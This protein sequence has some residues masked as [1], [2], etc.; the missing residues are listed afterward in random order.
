LKS[1]TLSIAGFTIC[2]QSGDGTDISVEDGYLP[3]IISDYTGKPDVIIHSERN[4]P[5]E[6]SKPEEVIFRAQDEQKKY[7]TVCKMG[8]AYKVL[9]YNQEANEK[10]Q[11]VALLNKDFSEWIIY[12]DSSYSN[13]TGYPLQYPLGP[14][15]L[16]YITVRFDAIMIHASGINDTSGGRIFCGFSGTGKSTMAAIWQYTGSTII[17]DDRLIIRKENEDYV[18]YNTPMLF[19]DQPKK[20]KLEA[21]HLIHH[22]LENTLNKLNGAFAVSSVMAFCIQNNY[23]PRFIDHH[24]AFLSELCNKIPVYEVGF[25]PDPSIIDFIKSH[26]D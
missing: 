9:I 18:I 1:I 24:L 16:Y 26:A 21:I 25:K 17:N 11:H 15:V 20:A 8:D 3:F 10:I 22:S 12:S 23:N 4:I 7:Y 5:I 13:G 14:L 6:L 19:K 2:L